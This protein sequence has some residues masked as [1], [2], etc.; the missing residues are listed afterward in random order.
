MPNG[1]HV[2]SSL[3]V[4]LRKLSDEAEHRQALS[5][6]AGASFP[7][8]QS[9][10]TSDQTIRKYSQRF[11]IIPTPT[12]T[13]LTHTL[14]LLHLALYNEVL[15][16]RIKT[17]PSTRRPISLPPTAYVHSYIRTRNT[18]GTRP[19]VVEFPAQRPSVKAAVS[20]AL[21]ATPEQPAS[22]P[23]AQ[24]GI[25]VEKN[26]KE[27]HNTNHPRV[28]SARKQ[29]VQLLKRPIKEQSFPTEKPFV[30]IVPEEPRGCQYVETN[31]PSYF[32]VR[33]R[34]KK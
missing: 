6:E 31:A 11:R 23:H 28:H 21:H 9:R 1:D 12:G 8:S 14:P 19:G 7:P 34:G 3:R 26:K 29:A 10:L 4:P 22:P 24:V 16:H 13:G 18:T 32:W 27:Q 25:I 20:L 30:V 2:Q 5:H 15:T 17:R 33:R